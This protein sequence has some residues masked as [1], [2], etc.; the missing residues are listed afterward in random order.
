MHQA[1]FV[2]SRVELNLGIK[3]KLFIVFSFYLTRQL[4]M[5]MKCHSQC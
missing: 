5:M 2:N 4:S 3:S 1:E